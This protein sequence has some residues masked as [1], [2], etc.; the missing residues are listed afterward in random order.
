MSRRIITTQYHAAGAGSKL[1]GYPDRLLKYIPAEVVGG[2]IAISG[3]LSG[4]RGIV[5]GTIWIVFEVM[6]VLAAAWTWKQ[7]S[8]PGK[9][10][11]VTQIIVATLAFVVWVFALGGP[12]ATLDF[13]HP[14]YGSLLLIAY[15]LAVP[16]IPI[17]Q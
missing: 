8:E 16:L 15:T 2:W 9:P 7:T 10:L 12:F 17:E 6:V 14:V 1:D 13:Y 3:L 5:T 11:A 4:A